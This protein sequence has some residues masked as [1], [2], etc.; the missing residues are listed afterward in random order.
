MKDENRILKVFACE[1]LEQVSAAM[2]QWQPYLDAREKL[3]ALLDGE[4]RESLTQ[5]ERQTL[6]MDYEMAL[7]LASYTMGYQKGQ[8]GGYNIQDIYHLLDL[9]SPLSDGELDC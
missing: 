4:N 5:E 1:T 9:F 3:F 2:E 6:L 8:D 7:I